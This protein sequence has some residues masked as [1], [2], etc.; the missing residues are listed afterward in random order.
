MSTDGSTW[1]PFAEGEFPNQLKHASCPYEVHTAL[2]AD[3]TVGSVLVQQ[4]KLTMVNFY[5][6][7]PGLTSIRVNPRCS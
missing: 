7:G 3:E 6:K 4:V 2:P 1:Q 5:E